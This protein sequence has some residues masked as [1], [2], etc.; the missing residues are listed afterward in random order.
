MPIAD[1]CDLAASVRIPYPQLVN[2]YGCRLGERVFV[3]PFVEIQKGA[4]VGDDCRI[5]SHT[6]ICEG[7]HIARRVFVGHGVI[8]INDRDPKANNPDWKL[9][10]TFVEDDVSIGSGAIIM[11]GV[12]LGAGCR[13]G[14]GAVVTR[15]VP[16]GRTVAGVPARIMRR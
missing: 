9:E 5:Q 10:E 4:A 3:G 7:V 12:R 14:C 16:A 6:F 1:S 8:F 2:L 13:I 15:D 11:C